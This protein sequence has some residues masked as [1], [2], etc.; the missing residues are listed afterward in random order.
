MLLPVALNAL[1]LVAEEVALAPPAQ[2]KQRM[3]DEGCHWLSE[4]LPVAL[5]ALLL[6]AV[7]EEEP[8]LA[9]PAQDKGC[10]I[11]DN[12]YKQRSD[13]CMMGLLWVAAVV[14]ACLLVHPRP[15]AWCGLCVLCVQTILMLL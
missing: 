13:V 1:L 14:R 5:N 12:V 7:A 6:V 8:A 10:V 9:P 4:L 2:N 15:V 11:R 3:C